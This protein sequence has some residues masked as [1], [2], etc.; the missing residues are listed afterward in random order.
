[1]KNIKYFLYFLAAL[2]GV[3]ILYG[4]YYAVIAYLVVIKFIAIALILTGAVALYNRKIKK[5]I[6]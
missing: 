4:I 1:M 5:K 3:F 6:E 2:L